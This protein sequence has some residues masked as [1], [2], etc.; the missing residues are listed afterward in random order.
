MSEVFYGLDDYDC[1]PPKSPTEDPLWDD[2]RLGPTIEDTEAKPE[3]SSEDSGQNTSNKTD[4]RFS[5]R[6]PYF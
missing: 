2:P 1:P 5:C 4:P 6:N 3:H